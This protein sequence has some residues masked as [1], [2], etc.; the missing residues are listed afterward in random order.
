MKK[1]SLLFALLLLLS[2]GL[3]AQSIAG[4]WYGTLQIPGGGQ[5]HV[6]FHIKQEGNV[7]TTTMDSPD[8]GAS[9]LPVDQTTVEGRQ[10]TLTAAKFQLKYTGSYLPDS[11][12][13]KGTFT[14]GPG[15]MPLTLST[16]KPTTAAI[17]KPEV[18]PQDPISFPYKRE[19]VVFTNTKAGNQLAGT[20]TLPANGKAK[21]IVVLITGSGPQNR[22]EEIKQFNHRPFLVWSDWL[23]RNGIAVLRYDDRGVG[24]STGT[25][26]TATS[27][28]FASDAAAAVDFIASRPDLKGLSV[29]L[30][31]HSEG[32]M[33]APMVASGDARIK[34]IILLAGPGVPIQELM[35]QQTADQ[36]RL[37]GAP[38]EAISRSSNTNQKIYRFLAAHPDLS[39]AELNVQLDTLMHQELRS[40]P[41]RDL[42]GESIDAISQRTLNSLSGPWYRYFV[43]FQPAQY[44][45]KVKCPVLALN[46]T[47]DMQVSCTPNLAGIKASLE[48]GG[49]RHFQI[50]PLNGL[51]HLL[52]QAKTGGINEYAQIPETVNP[53]ALEKVSAWIN[54]L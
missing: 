31:G 10:L 5:L 42:Q 38:A 25:F 43:G 12:L 26:N 24:A 50:V 34:F 4:T 37:G 8:Q 2:S 36:M 22:D 32:G 39:T 6:V 1:I 9:G 28:D 33:I 3:F 48:K 21:K 30:M 13:I 29:G 45:T 49:N 51:N 54:T 17:V 35:V 52:Q 14:Q 16:N 23:T 19:E 18:R 20:L 53:L 40:Y 7:Y 41:A 15:S 11:A 27:A 47:L 46:G 44:L